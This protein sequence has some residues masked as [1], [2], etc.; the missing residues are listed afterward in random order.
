MID[1]SIKDELNKDNFDFA[2]LYEIMEQSGLVFK[3]QRLHWALG[4]ATFDTIYLDMAKFSSFTNESKYFIILHEMA[5]GKRIKKFGKKWVIERMSVENFEDFAQGV[6]VEEII[7][8]RYAC[9]MIW[10]LLKHSFPRH[11][12][13]Q[14]HLPEVQ[15]YYK[16]NI[17]PI[18]GKVQYKEENY[19]KLFDTY[20]IKD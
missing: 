2:P 7:A 12:T 10:K 16:P 13:Q 15:E 14:L 9:Y 19:N 6:F 11:R 5:H 1:K 17:E 20:I 18:F 3:N 4:I 8:D